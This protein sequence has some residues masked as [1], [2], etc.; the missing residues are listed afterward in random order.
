MS[1]LIGDTSTLHSNT[2]P[3]TV[4]VELLGASGSGSFTISQRLRSRVDPHASVTIV[5]DVSC[6]ISC[7]PA[8][9]KAAT[10]RLAA[11][12]SSE[13][14]TP[15]TAAQVAS[16]PGAVLAQHSLY[17]NALSSPVVFG[18]EVSTVIKPKQLIGSEPKF[19]YH[20]VIT[21]GEA[22]TSSLLELSGTL[23]LEGLGYVK[24]W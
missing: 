9:D 14:A 23:K 13:A 10:L 11:I 8:A 5:G 4:V 16:I 21:G 22:T 18:P 2:T 20:F 7:P 15:S 6:R 19:V 24:S 3:F 12:P 1:E 17:V